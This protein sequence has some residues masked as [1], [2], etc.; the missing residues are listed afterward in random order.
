MFIVTTWKCP[1]P[2]SPPPP[3]PPQ[4]PNMQLELKQL[5][6]WDAVRKGPCERHRHT[7]SNNASQTQTAAGKPVGKQCGCVLA[8]APTLSMDW[9]GA[10]PGCCYG[11]MRRCSF[12][13][14]PHRYFFVG[15]VRQQDCGTCENWVNLPHRCATDVIIP[16]SLCKW[17]ME[18]WVFPV[19]HRAA[20]LVTVSLPTCPSC[21]LNFRLFLW[22]LLSEI[23]R[24][25]LLL[26][27]TWICGEMLI[28]R[29]F[30][31]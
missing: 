28:Y 15:I 2:P 4:S 26:T 19:V 12:F 7:Y 18:S 10:S 22:P 29:V 23:T 27:W 6:E 16:P 21:W 14:Y 13:N 24:L 8:S 11:C 20:R 25:F 31:Q 3:H 30:D 9:N 17:N 1:S 5:F